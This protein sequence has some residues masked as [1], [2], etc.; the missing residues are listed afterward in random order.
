[1]IHPVVGAIELHCDILLV[2]ELD[3]RVVLYTAAPG[4]SAHEAL[5]L[6]RVVGTQDLTT[7][8]PGGT[9]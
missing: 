2:P 3:Q 5:Q 8:A 6:L 1:M 9:A 7:N 4:T